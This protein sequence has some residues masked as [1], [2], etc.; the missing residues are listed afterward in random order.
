MIGSKVKQRSNILPILSRYKR[1]LYVEP[2][3]GACG[4]LFG[5]EKENAEVY[6]DI[7]GAFCSLLHVLKDKDSLQ[8]LQDLLNASPKSRELWYEANEI[9]TT[10]IKGESITDL[11]NAAGMKDYDNEVVV[12]YS[13][14]YMVNCGFGGKIASGYGGGET[15]T[16]A[17]SSAK[18]Y[19]S[20]R[21]LLSAFS[22]RLSNTEIEN[23][24]AIDCI[25]R[26]D[27]ESTLFY[28][29]PPY[30]CATRNV[31]CNEFIDEEKLVECLL[32]IKGNFVLSCYETLEYQKLNK[33]CDRF[34]TKAQT[35]V[36][37]NAR[38]SKQFERIEVVYAKKNGFNGFLF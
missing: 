21:A 10:F 9:Y 25:K 32:E 22:E 12:A 7:N 37:V 17:C 3:G 31:Y 29:D 1:D 34:E 38:K 30:Q 2:F 33:I 20:R 35:C 28:L 11:K 27:H 5:K 23:L 19:S 8:E 4:L 24:D 18:S 36:H 16:H 13:V 15:D 14:F 26:Y 6:N